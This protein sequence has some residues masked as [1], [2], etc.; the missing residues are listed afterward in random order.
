M[1]HHDRQV[2]R[3]LPSL[4]HAIAHLGVEQTPTGRKL[5]LTNPRLV[6]LE[7]VGS[8]DDCTMSDLARAL[9]LP[10]PLATRLID[11]LHQ[12]GLVTRRNDE[13]D[14]RRVRLSLTRQ[15]VRAVRA[16][17][18]ELEELVSLAVDRLSDD[19]AAALAAGLES[20][21]RVLHDA[22]SPAALPPH[23]HPGG[24]DAGVGAGRSRK[25]LV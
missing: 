16:A 3:L 15:G 10:A 23:V 12:R 22:S 21:L 7:Y 4:R 9:D 2:A 14:R 17:E 13:R 5:G 8:T 19:E 20:F 1:S 24:S 11:E 25:D 18:R 6:A